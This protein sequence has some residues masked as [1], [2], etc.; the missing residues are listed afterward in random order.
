[1][2]LVLVLV[3]PRGRMLKWP[4]A[5]FPSLLFSSRPVSG[6]LFFFSFSFFFRFWFAFSSA[7]P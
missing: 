1:V 5:P 2:V 4:N 7:K 3:L 6:S